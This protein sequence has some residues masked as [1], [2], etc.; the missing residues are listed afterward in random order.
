MAKTDPL[1]FPKGKA[2]IRVIGVGG[3][4]NNAVNRMI[5]D[6]VKDIDFI[7]ANTDAQVLGASKA[8]T[9]IQLGEKLT[10]G[11]GAGG[12]P[13]V[14]FQAAQESREEIKKALEGADMVFITA[15]M[16]GGTGTGAAPVV[17]EISRSMGILTVGVVTKPF[18]AEGPKRN[19]HADLGIATLKRQTDTLII[20]P[21]EK[22][23]EVADK[24]ISA[25]AAYKLA[26]SI[27]SQ[28]VQA[29]SDLITRPGLINVDFADVRS[30]MS[31]KGIAHMG[32]GRA[33]GKNRA[34]QA[35]YNALNNPLLDTHINGATS[36]LVSVTGTEDI[37]LVETTTPTTL[38]N[39]SAGD[40]AEI[41]CGTA[42]N[43]ELGEELVV[44][45][46]ATGYPEELEE[47]AG[48]EEEDI[49]FRKAEKEPVAIKFEPPRYGGSS[50]YDRERERE[51]EPVRE[52]ER[53]REPIRE[54]ETERS[55]RNR[56]SIV[57]PDFASIEVPVW[58][59]E[60]RRK[61]SNTDD[62][63]KR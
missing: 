42:I 39:G 2:K 12:K 21:N 60:P 34:E 14:G 48:Y 59:K 17:A 30:I 25:L 36:F 6:E 32:I 38:I 47:R 41:I 15:G 7:A 10:R 31:N 27:L 13:E 28:G 54:R 20:I 58:L 63:N 8:E 40:D 11:L 9:L 37:T 44:M 61:S 35:A 24:N 56:P 53:E 23:F 43:S 50:S 26:D 55:E 22:L 49:E 4:G 46:V 57:P 45:V 1:F 16:G 29:I 3:G 62:R 33:A 5:D 51:R 18:L 52:R 19:K